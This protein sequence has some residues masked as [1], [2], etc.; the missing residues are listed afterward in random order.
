MV[1]TRKNRSEQVKDLIKQIESKLDGY[2]LDLNKLIEFHTFRSQ[3]SEKY[4]LRNCALIESQFKGAIKVAGY[5]Q[6]KTEGYQVQ[7]GQQS[8]KILA[9]SAW[10]MVVDQDGKGIVPLSKATSD[11]KDK[12]KNN[13]LKTENRMGYRPVSVF[14]IHQTDCPIEEYPEY[15]QQFYLLG[16]TEKFQEFFE[17]LDNY[18]MENN[19][20]KY[21][22]ETRPSV[23]Q[24]AAK[25]FYVPKDHSIWIDPNLE[26]KQYLKTTIHELAHAKLHRNSELPGSLKEYQ[27]ELTA[28]VV[29][30]Y[31]GLEATEPTTHYIQ[32]HLQG[33]EIKEKEKLVEEVLNLSNQMIESMEVYLEKE[34]GL[35]NEINKEVNDIIALEKAVGIS[36]EIPNNMLDTLNQAREFD[37]VSERFDM[38][39]NNPTVRTPVDLEER[40]NKN[41]SV[42]LND[43]MDQIM[44]KKSVQRENEKHLTDRSL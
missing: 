44:G 42:S 39:D 34:H 14:D 17:S 35:T 27:A 6:W 37:G 15:L 31:F 20:G 21:T 36:N 10:K 33:M 12:V 4:S 28:G 11:I 3:M 13:E 23:E 26:Q 9:P 18:R 8:L 1:K 43:R 24:S 38:N 16:Q 32:N 7:K 5:N 29:S 30:N 40:K 2:V 25:G 22:E 19:I 41:D